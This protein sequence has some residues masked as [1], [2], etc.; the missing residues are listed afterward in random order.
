MYR[1]VRKYAQDWEK[2]E[3]RKEYETTPCPIILRD[4]QPVTQFKTVL[5]SWLGTLDNWSAQAELKAGIV[6]ILGVVARTLGHNL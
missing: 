2:H 6:E 5:R 3:L 1:R 4:S